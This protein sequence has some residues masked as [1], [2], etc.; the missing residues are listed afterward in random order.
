M[1]ILLNSSV[2]YLRGVGPQRALTLEE[3]GISTVADL[4]G[5]LPFRYEDRIR[6]TK[7]AEIIPGQV[8]TILAE[9]TAGGGATVRFGRG[10][11]AIFHA[12]L[13][14]GSGTLHARF[15][16]GAY[17]EGRMKEGQRFVLHGKVEVDPYRPARLEMVNPQ[18]ES[19]SSTEGASS[20]STE[21]GRIVPIYEA[22]GAIGS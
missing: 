8:H 13:R 4:L 16:H 9:V 17:L 20:D 11:P 6:F 7:I 18:I 22:L 10:R 12:T 2:K 1:G 5:Y 21:V 14:D 19:V 15:F 3:R